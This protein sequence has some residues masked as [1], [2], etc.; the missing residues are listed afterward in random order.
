MPNPSASQSASTRQLRVVEI[1]ND[2]GVR[3]RRAGRQQRRQRADEI[4]ADERSRSWAAVMKPTP[5]PFANGMRISRGNAGKN[6]SA[7][8]HMLTAVRCAGRMSRRMGV[9]FS[10]I[11]GSSDTTMGSRRALLTP[12]ATAVSTARGAGTERRDQDDLPRGDPQQ[13]G[14]GHDPPQAEAE[15]MRQ[16]G[17]ADIG[18]DQDIGQHRAPRGQEAGEERRRRRVAADGSAA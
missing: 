6:R 16:R 8:I 4:V 15:V 18:P 17:D 13:Q 3:K 11:N 1:R 9:S 2:I 10:L 14:R 7:S 5:S 12:T